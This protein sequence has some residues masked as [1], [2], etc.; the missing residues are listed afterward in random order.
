MLVV[1]REQAFGRMTDKRRGYFRD[2]PAQSLQFL[3]PMRSSGRRIAEEVY[4]NAALLHCLLKS[5]CRG[6]GAVSTGRA[7]DSP[8]N[9]R[10]SIRLGAGLQGCLFAL[11][12][13]A[14]FS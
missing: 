6:S 14:A 7:W 12:A 11:R 8:G 1:G 2:Q 3:P 5:L 4:D 13:A 9:D 10:M